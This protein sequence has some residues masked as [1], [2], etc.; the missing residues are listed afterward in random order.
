M[1]E[2]RVESVRRVF[3]GHF[4]VDEA[5]ATFQKPDGTWSGP[6]KRLSVERGDAAA[7]LIHDPERNTLVLV[8]QFRYPTLRH[9]EPFLLEI[10]AGNVD[11]G[12]TPEAAAIREAKEEVGIDVRNVREVARMYGSPGGLSETI[13][14]YLAE[15]R[16]AGGG[17]GLEGEDV[18]VVETPVAE[19]MAML[20]RG[21][22]RDAKTQLA[23]L[24]F[25]KRE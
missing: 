18:E 6:T 19:A 22:I 9:G 11:E 13:T 12:E 20:A 8:R 4:K 7:V 16:Y 3:D 24:H 15:G 17:G 14:I 1:R 2:V 25:G 21:E 23:L 10:V 5:T